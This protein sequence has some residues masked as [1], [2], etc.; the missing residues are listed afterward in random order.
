EPAQAQA[1]QKLMLHYSDREAAECSDE[2]LSALRLMDKDY[3]LIYH[4]RGYLEGPE[5]T[6]L[7]AER[8]YFNA[9]Y[10]LDK[11]YPAYLHNKLKGRSCGL[12]FLGYAPDSWE[13]R[14]LAKVLL[15]QR[16]DHSDPALVIQPAAD[17]FSNL[18]WRHLKCDQ[19]ADL[20]AVEFV[21]NI[22]AAL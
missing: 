18:F 7:L 22:R 2:Q 4:P 5:D 8:D 21:D 12:W 16:R 10:L 20:G 3:I 17:A 15:H 14:L 13:A 11:K 6:L 1:P 19:Y 9:S